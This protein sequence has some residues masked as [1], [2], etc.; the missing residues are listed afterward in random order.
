MEIERKYLVKQLPEN[1]GKYPHFVIEQGYL[2]TKPTIRIRRKNND[3][4]LTYKSRQNVS[5]A[6]DTCVNVEE[7]FPLSKEAYEHLKEKTDGILVC[8]TRYCIP[9][10]KYTIELDVFEGRQKGVILAE[11]E[12]ETVEEANSFVP[13]VW[14]GED[15]SGDY[16]YRNNYMATQKG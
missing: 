14:F 12:F 9:Y 4:I 3:Y 10:Q 7:E 2:C 13:P 15:V 1:L 6:V 16:H 8:K 11:V 5:P